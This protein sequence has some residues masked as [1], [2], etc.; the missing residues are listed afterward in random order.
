M[1]N[2][3]PISIQFV[4]LAEAF[5]AMEA[6]T[7]ELAPAIE[8]TALGFGQDVASATAAIV[9][10]LT[11]TLAASVE[12]ESVIDGVAVSIG[13]PGS[14]AEDYAGWIE[15][16]GTRGRP[17][18]PEGRYLYPTARAAQ[19]E[20]E[21]RLVETAIESVGSFPWPIPVL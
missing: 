10:V 16:G 19:P 13:G 3:S 21:R 15:F 14:G 9:P 5:V 7:I 1:S 4:G 2:A 12:A 18:V 17:W 11:G 6:W 8:A 20:W